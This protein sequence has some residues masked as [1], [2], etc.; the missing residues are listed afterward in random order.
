MKSG[1]I[2]IYIG[3]VYLREGSFG[4]GGRYIC[5]YICICLRLEWGF[6]PTMW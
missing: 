1:Q 5:I 3:K 6:C 4:K 2:N